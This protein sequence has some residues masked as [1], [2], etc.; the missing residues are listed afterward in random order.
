MTKLLYVKHGAVRLKDNPQFTEAW[1]AD[2]I[3][4]DP[5]ILGLGKLEVKDRERRQVGAG[6]LDLLLFDP[7]T[8][9]RYE[10]ELML[11][12]VNESHIIRTLEYWDIERKRYRDYEHCAVIVAEDITSRFF[13]V[14]NLF[15]GSIPIIAIQLNAIQ[16][17]NK[18]LLVFTKI[19]DEIVSG[20]DEEDDTE[21][22]RAYWEARLSKE[23][24]ATL[25]K[26]PVILRE[27]N[28]K[29]SLTYREPYVGLA[30][31]KRVNNF[32][33]FKKAKQKFIRV[34]VKIDDK[35]Y[36]TTQIEDAGLQLLPSNSTR[37]RLIFQISFDEAKKKRSLLEKLFQL[38][39]KE[40]GE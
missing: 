34:E 6:R 31:G 5:S 35:D 37:A 38:S 40:H 24:L 29:L 27:I 17:D 11:G 10:V 1:V 12:A 36:W 4:E 19:L 39:Y 16:T 3:A 20:E 14:I 8:D 21:V 25:D 23:S 15:N 28:S 7:T 30:D 9:K 33:V 18:L 13:N 22:N 32:V 26:C 2:R